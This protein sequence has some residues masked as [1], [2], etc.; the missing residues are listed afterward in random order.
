[1]RSLRRPTP[2]EVDDRLG[3]A[4]DHDVVEVVGDRLRFT[5]PLLASAVYQKIPPARRRELHARLATIVRDPEERAR[6]LALS[7]EGPDVAVAAA[8]EEA[9]L[10]A[11]SRGAPQSAAELWEMARR[12]TPK[13]RGKD[14]VRRTHEAG[15]AHYECGDTSL[16]RTVLEQA[17]DLS[18]AGPRRARVLLDL[19][20]VVAANEGWRPAVDRLHG[21]F[22]R[23]GR[24]SHSEGTCRAEP[25]VRLA[26]QGRPRGIGTACS[27]GAG[28]GRGAAGPTGDGRGVP[29]LSLRRVP[30]R[31]GCR[32][33]RCWIAGSP[34]KG[35]CRGEFISYVL[36]ASFVLA[37][38]LK[39]TDRLDEARETFTELLS[40][41]SAH[42][43][44]SPVPQIQ[45]HLAELECRAGNWDAA[46][47]HA[48]ES[49]ATAHRQ[50]MGSFSSDGSLRGG[51]GGS[52]SGSGD[53]AR[54]KP[55]RGCA[56]LKRPTRSSPD[57]EPVGP[58]VPRAFPGRLRRGR[59]VSVQGDRALRGDGGS[60]TRVLP[61]RP[62]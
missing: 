46:M 57:P 3:P 27:R 40:G 9:A 1:M 44:E 52:P 50:A 7:V 34:W 21:C 49:I 2:S 42:G 18:M 31:T 29:S 19:G 20:M 36:R 6:H 30:P 48:R 8:L 22:E 60:G 5:H 55:S 58:R 33:S 12:A 24:R 56:W 43:V 13:D 17:V 61:D 25:R 54:R 41:A 35:T 14:L 38:L 53:A 16:A 47:E 45:Y 15:V 59:R 23:G 28:A 11:S 10:L 51:S 62:G 37:Q 26:V 4:I 32:S 39:F